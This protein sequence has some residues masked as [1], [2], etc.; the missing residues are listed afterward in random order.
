[1]QT[2]EPRANSAVEARLMG[3]IVLFLVFNGLREEESMRR[4][5]EDRMEDE[6][7]AEDRQK[8]QKKAEA[9]KIK[10]KNLWRSDEKLR[11]TTL[12]LAGIYCWVQFY[13]VSK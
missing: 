2:Q 12:A 4:K 5:S 8:Q 11:T 6:K 7:M 3:D 10:H 1:M 9:P 13:R